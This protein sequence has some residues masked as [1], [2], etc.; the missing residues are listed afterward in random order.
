[1]SADVIDV[2]DKQKGIITVLGSGR[3]DANASPILAV[4]SVRK[5]ALAIVCTANLPDGVSS[6]VPKTLHTSQGMEVC[7]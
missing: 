4:F 2:D 7:F 1:M 3:R 5:G 6:P